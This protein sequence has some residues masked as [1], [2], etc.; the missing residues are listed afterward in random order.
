MFND[1]YYCNVIISNI[2]L[3]YFRSNRTLGGSYDHVISA[4]FRFW[5]LNIFFLKR[6]KKIQIQG[7]HG[8]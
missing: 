2:L 1:C 8:T 7:S 3:L 4:V 6:D 5:F